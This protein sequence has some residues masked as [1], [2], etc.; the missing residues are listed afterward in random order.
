MLKAVY[1]ALV[2]ALRQALFQPLADVGP[3]K[4]ADRTRSQPAKRRDEPAGA[5]TRRP[6]E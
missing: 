3:R 5:D 4:R 6:G 2:D 1:E